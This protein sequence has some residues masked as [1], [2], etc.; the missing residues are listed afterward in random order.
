[1]HVFDLARQG[2]VSLFGGGSRANTGDTAAMVGARERFLGRGHYDRIAQAVS[3]A[4]EPD[5]RGLCVDLAGGTGHYL[6]TVLDHHPE[7]L[8]LDLELSTFALRRAAR[9][10]DRIAAVAADVWQR[11]PVRTG[12]AAAAISVFG[13]RNLAELGRVLAADGR[14]IVVT[15]TVRHLTELVERLGLVTVD[16]RK[17]ERLE[18]QLARWHIESVTVLD[19]AV[20]L[21]HR[22]VLDAVLMGPS[23]HHVDGAVLAAT[24]QVM[25]EPVTVT[26]SVSVTVAGS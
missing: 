9:A 13:P 14:F 16:P 12:T 4:I 21:S 26:V 17:P 1:G 6:A 22:D 8:G 23:A 18:Q 25:P 2:Y 15:P 11:W 19:Y 20:E 10:H 3:D 24:V 5:A 7:L